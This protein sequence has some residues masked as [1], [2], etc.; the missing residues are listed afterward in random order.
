MLNI[1]SGASQPFDIRQL[2]TVC[3]ALYPIFMGLIE[4]L[5]SSFL[6]SLYILDISPL[7]KNSFPICWWPF[8]LMDSKTAMSCAV[9]LSWT[10]GT[11]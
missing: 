4:F 5:E 11:S 7:G 10:N 2:R 3:L 6:S 9:R 8:C 1:F